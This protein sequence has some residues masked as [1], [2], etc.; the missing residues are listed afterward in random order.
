MKECI[1]CQQFKNTPG[2]QQPWHELP[3]VTQSMKRISI[4]VTDMGG[5]VVGQ[6]YVLT[7]ID[8]YS[9]FVTFYP[10]KSRTTEQIIMKL[11]TLIEVIGVPRTL[12]TGNAQELCAEPL[13][14]WSRENGIKLVHSTPYHPQGNSVSERMHRTTKAVLTILC[15]GHPRK[16][17]QYLK[18]CQKIL[19]SVVHETT[20]EQPHYLMFNRRQL[21]Y[22]GTELQDGRRMGR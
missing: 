20:G 1:T 17:P 13:K 21:R 8:H 6:R 16:W 19:N 5:G 18:V 4:G 3:P 22:V 10:L 14:R 12:L 2:L 7:V 15:K 11:D 9:R